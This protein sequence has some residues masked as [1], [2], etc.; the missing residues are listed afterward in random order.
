MATKPYRGKIYNWH[1]HS[2]DV[3]SAEEFYGESV[4][5]GYV[6][7][8]F[9]TKEPRMGS[10]YHTSWVVKHLPS[11]WITTRNSRYKLVGKEVI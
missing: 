8:G 9:R 6:I 3:K 4:G 5:L 11:G 2:F 7:Y 1:K 10:R